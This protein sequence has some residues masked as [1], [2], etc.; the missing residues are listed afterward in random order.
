M[1]ISQ[2]PQPVSVIV[3]ESASI[4]CVAS[5]PPDVDIVYVWRFNGFIIDFEHFVE[6]KE[7]CGRVVLC[8]PHFLTGVCVCVCVCVCLCVCVCVCLCVC[9]CVC[10]FACVCVCVYVCVC[11]CVCVCVWLCVCMV[12]F[13]CLH[14]CVWE[15][16]EGGIRSS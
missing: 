15:G 3:N 1:V 6:Y 8:R 11:V 7:V 12:V 16:G 14:V 13:V 5:A 4:I 10:M 2:P 9:V